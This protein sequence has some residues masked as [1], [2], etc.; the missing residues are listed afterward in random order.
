M[1]CMDQTEIFELWE[2]FYETSMFRMQ[3]FWNRYLLQLREKF[4]VPS[5]SYNISSRIKDGR[6][7]RKIMFFKVK[8]MLRNAKNKMD[9]NH[10]TILSRYGKQMKNTENRWDSSVSERKKW[11]MLYDQH[12]FGETYS[13]ESWTNF[14]FKAL[15]FLDFCSRIST[16]STTPRLCRSKTRMSTTIRRQNGGY[17]AVLQ[18]NSSQQTNASKSESA[19]RKKNEDNDCVADQK[20]RWKWHKEQQGNLPHTPSS[21]SSSLQNSSWQYWNLWWWPFPKLDE[22]HWVIFFLQHAISDC[23]NVVPTFRRCSSSMPWRLKS[24][25]IIFVCLKERHLSTMSSP[26]WSLSHFLSSNPPQ[27]EAPPGNHDLL[28]DDFVH[29]APVLFQTTSSAQEPFSL[30]NHESGWNLRNTCRTSCE[31][32]ELSTIS[33]S[34][35]EI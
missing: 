8:D 31:P 29:R 18:T 9:G 23:W 13:Y 26:Y 25:W 30:V 27:H 32:K 14:K 12:C 6:L 22:G 19:I 21:S 33:G 16:H 17:K 28:Q 15:G 7:Q 2:K 4:E 34:S 10:P 5:K 1:H 35:L 3:F 24:H 20:T 11:H